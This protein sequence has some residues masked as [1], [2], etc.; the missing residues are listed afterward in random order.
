MH[1]PVAA[2][3]GSAGLLLSQTTLRRQHLHLSKLRAHLLSLEFPIHVSVLLIAESH[4]QDRTGSLGKLIS[5]SFAFSKKLASN[6]TAS[7]HN[8]VKR[9]T[10][11]QIR[12]Q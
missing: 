9:D 10:H 3:R 8:F 7:L 4:T 11:S 6:A 2:P 5:I 12:G 1:R